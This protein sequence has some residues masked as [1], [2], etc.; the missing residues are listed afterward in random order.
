[1]CHRA[2]PGVTRRSADATAPSS[3]LL[4]QPNALT[5]AVPLQAGRAAWRRKSGKSF[6]ISRSWIAASGPTGCRSRG[7]PVLDNPR[8]IWRRRL[9][10]HH[11]RRTT[12]W[13]GCRV[14]GVAALATI[15]QSPTQSPAT[16]LDYSPAF[17][18]G[19][20]LAFELEQDQVVTPAGLDYASSPTRIKRRTRH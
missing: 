12:F 1:M 13:T 5:L 2:S 20:P 4:R 11:H 18:F 17:Q 7:P 15:V 6:E 14:C 3:G 9:P 19:H 10:L 8:L 16:A